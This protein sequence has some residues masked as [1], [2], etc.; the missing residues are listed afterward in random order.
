M[1]LRFFDDPDTGQPHIY[2]HGV[3]EDEVREVLARPAEDRP[4]RTTRERLSE[5]R[6]QAD[7]CE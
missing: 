5:K 2:G 3:R 6:R 4:V 7:I 1:E